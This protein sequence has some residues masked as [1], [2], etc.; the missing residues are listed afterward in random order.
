MV[1]KEVALELK[2][3]ELMVVLKQVV[4]VVIVLLAIKLVVKLVVSKVYT[5]KLLL[6]LP[7][8]LKIHFLTFPILQQWSCHLEVFPFLIVS[9]VRLRIAS[10]I[11]FS[12]LSSESCK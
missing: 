12:P 3:V 10:L 9:I 4:V 2:V 5:F 1:L 7:S 8:Q 11:K 6:R